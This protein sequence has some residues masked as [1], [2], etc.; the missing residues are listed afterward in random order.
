MTDRNGWQDIATAPRDGLRVLVSHG[1]T[2]TPEIDVAEWGGK[3]WDVFCGERCCWSA[4]YPTH[5]QPLP[6]APEMGG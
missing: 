2:E 4:V 3:T 1:T 5:W 6:G